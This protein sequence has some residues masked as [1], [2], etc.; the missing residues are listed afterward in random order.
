[1]TP[2]DLT[3]KL[4][5]RDLKGETPAEKPKTLKSPTSRKGPAPKNEPTAN[6]EE[7]KSR[8]AEAFKAARYAE[9]EELLSSS[10][11]IKPDRDAYL[12]LIYAQTRLGRDGPLTAT[13]QESIQNFP[14]EVRFNRLYAK[15]LADKGQIKEALAQVAKGLQKHPGDLQLQMLE[16]FLKGEMKGRNKK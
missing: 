11:N 7:L 13:L 14:E 10:L 2:D 9:A 16:D 3:L 1:M 15:H 4:I 12:Y 6:A 5:K 8:G